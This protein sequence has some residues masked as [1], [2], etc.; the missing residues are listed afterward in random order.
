MQRPSPDQRHHISGHYKTVLSL[1]E[2][3]RPTPAA[4]SLVIAPL[5]PMIAKISEDG[6][7]QRWS[8]LERAPC[9]VMIIPAK[10][11]LSYK[12]QICILISP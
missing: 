7:V 3:T 8:T 1:S 6:G 9:N 2:T 4:M 12:Y 11:R 5:H 10:I